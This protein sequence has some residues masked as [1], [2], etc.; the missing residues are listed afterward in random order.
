MTT[1][2]SQP[3]PSYPVPSGYPPGQPPRPQKYRPSWVWFLVGAGLI[4]VGGVAAV[5]LFIWT[6]AA[7]FT[8]DARVPIDGRPHTV[9]VDTDGDRMLWRS[10]D[11]FDPGCRVVDT[12]TGE[13]IRLRPVTSQFTRDTGDGDFVAAYRFAPGSGELEVTCSATPGADLGSEDRLGDPDDRQVVIGPAPTVGGFVGGLIATVA[14]GGLLGLLG[15]ATLI[16]NGVLWAT[17]PAR[18]KS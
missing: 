3:P 12:A 16:V 5:G 2:P 9:T 8:T 18:P 15:L 1:P 11:V 10:D 4:V 14:V 7:F 6:L 17:R 13:E